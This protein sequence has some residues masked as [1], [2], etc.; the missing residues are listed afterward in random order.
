MNKD[1]VEIII[2]EEIPFYNDV[3]IG[4]KD[5]EGNIWL[6]VN[7]TC[8]ALGLNDG[9]MKTQR[10]KIQED[11]VLSKGG[12]NFILPTKGGEQNLVMI[13]EKYI[14]LWLAKISITPKIQK[15]NPE[16]TNKLIT[17]QLECA[18][19]L[20]EHFMGTEEKKKQF[21][22]D[23]FDIK[24]R[25]V[26][27]EITDEFDQQISKIE[28]KYNNLS[29]VNEELKNQLHELQWDLS[30]GQN[31]GSEDVRYSKAI[32][33]FLISQGIPSTHNK[34]YI[35]WRA[36]CDWTDTSYELL[37]QQSNKKKWILTHIGIDVCEYFV[38]GVK[39]KKITQTET[40]HWVNCRV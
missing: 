18:D 7:H 31:V 5:K 32:D 19:V 16:L 30:S 20:H 15:E 6:S 4:G 8:R 24:L 34:Y 12:R 2:T 23:M 13:S 36:I 35:F 3:L 38:L 21:F 28:E 40:G 39:Q 1:K 11:I 33:G 22:N 17:Y 25:N 10:K 29:K 9:Q 37:E 14:P 26:V 27:K